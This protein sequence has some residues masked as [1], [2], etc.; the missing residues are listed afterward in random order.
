M[1][2]GCWHFDV[3]AV[4]G[5]GEPTVH[6]WEHVSTSWA[7]LESPTVK[8][9]RV[10]HRAMLFTG[11]ADT[12]GRWLSLVRELP[13]LNQQQLVTLQ[14]PEDPFAALNE[15]PAAAG[16]SYLAHL[17]QVYERLIRKCFLV[18]V[19]VRLTMFDLVDVH[20]NPVRLTDLPRLPNGSRIFLV[21]RLELT[22]DSFAGGSITV[23]V[24]D[25][26]TVAE[27]Q[28]IVWKACAGVDGVGSLLGQAI[29]A[30]NL[31]F[32]RR[33]D[34]DSQ[35]RSTSTAVQI[36]AVKTPGGHRATV[37]FYNL[38]NDERLWLVPEAPRTAQPNLHKLELARQQ[39][40]ENTLVEAFAAHRPILQLLSAASDLAR[41]NLTEEEVKWLR[42]H[43]DTRYESEAAANAVAEV[44]RELENQINRKS[45]EPTGA[46]TNHSNSNL[47]PT[48]SW[49]V[50]VERKLQICCQA[51]AKRCT[52]E[53]AVAV[54][55]YLHW[56][57]AAVQGA[58]A[59]MRTLAASGS[60]A[61]AG[62]IV[63]NK[64][65]RESALPVDGAPASD[66]HH[67]FVELPAGWAEAAERLRDQWFADDRKGGPPLGRYVVV[68]DA[69][70][71]RR[72]AIDGTSQI[73]GKVPAG[74]VI[75]L[76]ATT[77]LSDGTWRGQL[78][79]AKSKSSVQP[80][81]ETD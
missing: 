6:E 79:C 39:Q 48:L 50:E 15:K 57:G 32:I 66:P 67:I 72:P 51:L 61:C 7:K 30:E 59:T 26:D 14:L 24:K 74:T 45:T 80:P 33:T 28:W 18:Q 20:D 3:D 65:R 69:C 62:Q 43:P 29:G 52:D 46:C 4:G 41:R 77:R 31:R 27:V 68:V 58:S 2:V 37:C 64:S 63:T 9:L 8:R 54:A 17:A 36:L 70:A 25:S 21:Q 49:R 56:R 75:H 81:L 73:V 78:H 13:H 12:S 11:E 23:T 35:V 5:G 1:A 16:H 10:A 47:A 76:A 34:Q 71:R 60:D 19:A 22:F 53:I 42:T 38:R 44:Q 40:L 55:V